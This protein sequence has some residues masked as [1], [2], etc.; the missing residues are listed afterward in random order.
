MWPTPAECISALIPLC[1]LLA[2]LV[3]ARR[4]SSDIRPIFVNVVTGVAKSAQNNA[5]VYALALLF[6]LTASFSAFID[7]FKDMTSQALNA[8]SWHQ[9]AVA[10]VKVLN[11]FCVAIIAYFTKPPAIGSGGTNPP[12]PGSSP[13]TP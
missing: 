10:W 9:Y 6:G 7:V 5:M 8:M 3:A 2:V 12:F 11:P 4:L 13:S 1:A